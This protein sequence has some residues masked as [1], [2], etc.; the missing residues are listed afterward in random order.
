[1]R[2]QLRAG[3]GKPQMPEA[4]VWRRRARRELPVLAAVAT[5]GALGALSR[6]GVARA[7]PRQPGGF[8]WATFAINVSGCLAIV[9]TEH[10]LA[11]HPVTAL[12]YLAGTAAAALVAV[13]TGVVAT[14]SL[15]LR[16]ETR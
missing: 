1:M 10:L 2:S 9:E 6:Y 15:T 4:T 11:Y 7:W 16:R 5:G 12:A 13:Q 8:P 14:R 3:E